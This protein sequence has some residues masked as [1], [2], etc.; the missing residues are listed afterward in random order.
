MSKLVSGEATASPRGVAVKTITLD[1]VLGSERRVGV[2]K[3]DVE[4]HELVVLRGAANA[5]GAKRIRDI[6]FEDLGDYPSEVHTFLLERGYVIF[7]LHSK[8]LGP[9]LVPAADKAR[10]E[11]LQDGQNFLA[12]LDPQRATE[13]LKPRG[14]RS[15][16]K[17]DGSLGSCSHTRNHAQ[18]AARSICPGGTSVGIAQRSFGTVKVRIWRSGI[19]R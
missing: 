17:I 2:C 9:R 10:F 19:Q 5:L 6:V 12:T 14:W 11:K 15:L 3:I 16:R 13:K 7:S 18:L 4:G 1:E 8:V